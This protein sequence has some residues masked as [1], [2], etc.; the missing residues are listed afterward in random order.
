MEWARSWDRN[1]IQNVNGRPEKLE[2]KKDNKFSFFDGVRILQVLRKRTKYLLIPLLN[3]QRQESTTVWSG[4]SHQ[5]VN[6]EN[7][8]CVPKTWKVLYTCNMP[9][10]CLQHSIHLQYSHRELRIG[11]QYAYNTDAI[12]LHQQ[13]CISEYCI[14]YIR[15]LYI[16]KLCLIFD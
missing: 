1:S 8:I 4:L 12:R 13:Y 14:L 3:N 5:W 15:I 16:W 10:M 11:L 9:V 6:L 2:S 7:S